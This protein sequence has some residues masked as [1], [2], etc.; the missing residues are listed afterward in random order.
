MSRNFDTNHC[1][2][3]LFV[4]RVNSF[5]GVVSIYYL[6]LLHLHKITS[7]LFAFSNNGFPLIEVM[8]EFELD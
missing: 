7:E 1:A 3:K 8:I 4:K 2:A 6:L 5:I